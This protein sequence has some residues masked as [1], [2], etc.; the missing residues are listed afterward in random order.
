MTDAFLVTDKVALVTGGGNGIG[1]ETAIV[2]ASAGARVTATDVNE[3]GL[4]RTRTR[5]EE[6]GLSIATQSLDVADPAAISDAV[7]DVMAAHGQLDILVNAAGIM[8]MRNAL[9]VIPAEL[10]TVFRINVGGTFFACQAAGRVM[11]P[12]SSIV[13]LTSSI[14]DRTSPG[15]ITY[16]ISKGGV[17]Q[18][19][20]TFALELGPA[21]IRV[22]AIAPG[23]VET[24]MTDQHWTGNDGTI[25]HDRRAEYIAMMATASPLGVVGTTRDVALSVLQ[26]A[27]DAGSFITGQV[28]RINGGAFMA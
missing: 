11:T 8:I 5:A 4:L 14:Q 10:D 3:P 19:T 28:V 7:D 18:L 21:G 9:E 6:L 2:L 24:G 12:G 20:R 17:A 13:N 25:D 16:A 23:W 15:R 22:N 1:Q 26:L 27:S